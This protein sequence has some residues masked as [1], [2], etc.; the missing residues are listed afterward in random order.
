[1]YV[2]LKDLHQCHLFCFHNIIFIVDIDFAKAKFS[3]GKDIV[4]RTD[5]D[6]EECCISDM[7]LVS[8]DRI[9][10]VDNANQ[11]VKLVEVTTGRVLHRLQLQ[12]QPWGVCR[13]SGN[14]VAVSLVIAKIIQVS[15]FTFIIN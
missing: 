5:Q 10:A 12:S 6:K 8:D 2:N 7:C 15:F 4:V 9:V 1:M 11:S 13:M 14:R 3:Q